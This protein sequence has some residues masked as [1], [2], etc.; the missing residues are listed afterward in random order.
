MVLLEISLKIRRAPVAGSRII[1]FGSIRVSKASL[2]D[3]DRY[4]VTGNAQDCISV[5]L[6]TTITY[7]L[8]LNILF[9]KKDAILE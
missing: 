9:S 1:Q 7:P 4:Q 3:I 6:G 8:R 2:D 5:D